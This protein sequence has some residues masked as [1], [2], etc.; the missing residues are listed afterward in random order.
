[1]VSVEEFIGMYTKKKTIEGYTKTLKHFFSFVKADANGYFNDYEDAE[2]IKTQNKARDKIMMDVTRWLINLET[3][4]YETKE[5]QMKPYSP[6]SIQQMS[7][8][9]RAFLQMNHIDLGKSYWKGRKITGEALTQ[10]R[11]PTKSEI[12]QI[13]A[14]LDFVGRAFLY[15]QI[16]TGLRISEILSLDIKDVDFTKKPVRIK[17][18]ISKIKKHHYTFLTEEASK[19][20]KSWIEAKDE[21]MKIFKSAYKFNNTRGDQ[22]FEEFYESRPNKDKIFPL[23]G[24]HIYNRIN[25]ALRKAGL[26]QR[27]ENTGHHI[28]HP[29]SIG[30]KY[31]KTA[32]G[33]VLSEGVAD[34]LVGHQGGMNSLKHIYNRHQ[35]V[36]EALA[37]DFLKAE[38]VLTLMVEVLPTTEVEQFRQRL[39]KNEKKLENKEEKLYTIAKANNTNFE[40]IQ[41][42][43]KKI[44]T[45]QDEIDTRDKA[46]IDQQE[47]E[48]QRRMEQE[49]KP[50]INKF[51]QGSDIIIAKMKASGRSPEEI[52]AY[53]RTIEHGMKLFLR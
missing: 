12:R 13:M 14:H 45:L 28:L 7:G 24:T 40:I 26:D 5:G 44:D 34:A 25:E 36:V 51:K 27:D 49:Y 50:D 38:N 31:F 30:R 41:M 21:R 2:T 33:S 3:V 4:G 42:L 35:D 46:I 47:F 52:Q 9:I 22:T 43:L 15:V 29:H 10:D 53:K 37:Q 16:S 19:I 6:K 11:I 8:C 39:D 48:W 23:A 32:V 17:Y 18:Y 20:L 1:M